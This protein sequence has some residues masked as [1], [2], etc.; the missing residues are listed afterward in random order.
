VQVFLSYRRSDAGGHAGRLAETLASRIGRHRVVLDVTAAGGE[1][2]AAAV[3]RALAR[4]D[5]MLA[6]I[7][8]GWVRA[9]G[10]AGL[11]R[12]FQPDDYVHVELARALRRGMPV[13]A[14]LVGGTTL[15][16]PADLPPDLRGIVRQPAAT[17]RD[18]TWR[19]DV[20]ML[21]RR[22][23]DIRANIDAR[24]GRS[25]GGTR[26][27]PVVVGAA[28]VAVIALVAGALWAWRSRADDG[29]AASS[30]GIT[31][32][33]ATTDQTWH[34]VRP[35]PTKAEIVVDEGSLFVRV[36]TTRW[37]SLVAGS[38]QVV[39]GIELE[40][41][42][43]DSHADGAEIYRALVVAGRDYR[44]MCFAAEPAV[45]SASQKGRATVGFEV[46]CEPTGAV[47]LALR[48]GDTAPVVEGAA[49]PTCARA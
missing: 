15:P 39:L 37:R 8:P 26:R 5:A 7:G 12:L 36:A 41:L 32:C 31:A 44:V 29:S 14:V 23:E 40:N 38:F 34:E 20:A 16:A 2:L 4:C 45:V 11:R 3:D 35:V 1:P 6:V 47:T 30:T 18:E 25:S 13:I 10:P 33:P 48:G 28:L 46:G 22:I 43:P 42:S 49:S 24:R 21:L 17:V 19:E 27:R 9:A